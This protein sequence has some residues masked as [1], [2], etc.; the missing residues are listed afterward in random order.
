MNKRVIAKSAR[1]VSGPLVKRNRNAPAIHIYGRDGAMIV[2]GTMFAGIIFKKD[3]EIE[4]PAGGYVA[5]IDYAVH[6]LRGK[7]LAR[8]M[9]SIKLSSAILGGYHFAPGGN[10]KA[11]SGGDSAPAINPRSAWD[12]NFRPACK[13][14]R[15]MTLVE[16]PTGRFWCD[17]YL[18]GRDH[19]DH[20]TSCLGVTIA[21]GK[22]CPQN[23]VGGNFSKCD[24]ATA[25]AVLKHHGKQLLG[26]E[27]FFAAALGVTERSAAGRDPDITKLDAA[28][29]SRWG[30]MQAT[31]NLWAWGT[32]GHP[33]EPRPSIFGGSWLGGSHA[34]SRYANLDFWLVYSS[35]N[36]G[37]RGRSDHLQLG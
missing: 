13:D 8:P 16:G 15:G 25:I 34:G 30:L 14:P 6:V 23:P 7:V 33:T 1:K 20:G 3:T 36:L 37:A 21:D 19:L 5:G 10:A 4:K 24:F 17:I 35:G 12:R 11:S 9:S 31:G 32:D 29:T 18:L 2:A 27:E 26:A 22:N 28:R